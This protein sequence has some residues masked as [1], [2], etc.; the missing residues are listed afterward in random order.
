MQRE[1]ASCSVAATGTTAPPPPRAGVVV[2]QVGR[3]FRGLKGSHVGA[4]AGQWLV[5]HSH[6]LDGWARV[7][8]PDG[9][10]GL[11]PYSC[12]DESSLRPAPHLLSLKLM[13]KDG[14]PPPPL[15]PP[16]SAPPAVADRPAEPL[17]SGTPARHTDHTDTTTTTAPQAKDKEKEDDTSDND[18]DDGDTS[19][20]S[21]GSNSEGEDDHDDD[22]DDDDDNGD[23][24]AP[25]AAAS[26]PAC[27]VPP[28]NAV[29]GGARRGTRY[30]RTDEL[31]Q[32]YSA[33]FRRSL[34]HPRASAAAEPS[35]TP[36]PPRAPP[37]QPTVARSAS[38]SSPPP[39]PKPAAAAVQSATATEA[40]APAAA[41]RIPLRAELEKKRLRLVEELIES[42]ELYLRHLHIIQQVYLPPLVEKG[43]LV[44]EQERFLSS[45]VGLFADMHREF[46]SLL[47]RRFRRYSY[48]TPQP[49]P[50][51]IGDIFLTMARHHTKLRSFGHAAA[52]A[53]LHKLNESSSAF[54]RCIRNIEAS[55]AARGLTLAELLIA[56]L[57]RICK[58]PRF[59]SELLELTPRTAVDYELLRAAQEQ[60]VAV[61]TASNEAAARGANHQ[62]MRQI[63]GY[64][65]RQHLRDIMGS[66]RNFIHEGHLYAFDPPGSGGGSDQQSG[67][68]P[69]G[70]PVVVFLFSDIMVV[71][72]RL[73]SAKLL[74]PAKRHKRCFSSMHRIPLA[75][76]R[77]INVVSADNTIADAIIAQQ[78]QQQQQQQRVSLSAESST[79]PLSTD[80]P[81][82]RG[83]TA[84]DDDLSSVDSR[85]QQ[86]TNSDNR[87]VKGSLR[88]W[89][90]DSDSTPDVQS[91]Q[92]HHLHRFELQALWRSADEEHVLRRYLFGAE[93]EDEKRMWFRSIQKLINHA[94]LR[95]LNALPAGEVGDDYHHDTNSANGDDNYDDG[96]G[97]GDDDEEESSGSSR[98]KPTRRAASFSSASHSNSSLLAKAKASTTFRR[99]VERLRSSD[100]SSSGSGKSP[101]ASPKK[102]AA[103]AKKKHHTPSLSLDATDH[104]HQQQQRQPTN[105]QTQSE[106]GGAARDEVTLLRDEI[107]QLKLQLHT[108]R[109]FTGSLPW[110]SSS[111][112]SAV[113]AAGDSPM[114]PSAAGSSSASPSA[115]LIVKRRQRRSQ[116]AT[117]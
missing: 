6:S 71:A 17:M 69:T 101:P 19:D 45:N 82:P 5:I 86:Q 12:I 109:P 18:E 97:G 55:E 114:A 54:R 90:K 108:L 89:R 40:P 26:L 31:E 50:P 39:S 116:S 30:L 44:G 43:V 47:F 53:A 36:P 57:E 64:F 106:E 104:H 73:K 78:Q 75:S 10:Q 111:T 112:T 88:R 63:A 37:A 83:S 13:G 67:H 38:S 52:L 20:D 76:S 84:G 96:G 14:G 72:D 79:S 27:G 48:A 29:V 98:R 49:Q 65:S 23:D 66:S 110:D 41:E 99:K 28:E 21:L 51:P 60:I 61:V 7:S 34:H 107:E 32:L 115:S 113:A 33:L 70:K 80:A 58:Y 9:R 25:S 93:S 91:Q 3:T 105:D 46:H 2:G 77:I 94:L 103:P 42:E 8:H 92:T 74:D 59:L 81:S 87:K 95:Q 1:D 100:Q 68:T 85:Q 35:S 22:D 62:R 24:G 16:R 4:E 56:P 11:F 117:T 15:P 102:K